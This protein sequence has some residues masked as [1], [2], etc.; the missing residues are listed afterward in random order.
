MTH[1]APSDD[2]G[3]HWEGTPAELAA[4]KAYKQRKAVA[5][6]ELG[7]SVEWSR[8]GDPFMDVYVA[9][10][11]FANRPEVRASIQFYGRPS[12]FGIDGGMVSKLTI[13]R[14]RTDLIKRVL[15]HEHEHVETLFN[16]D[17]GPDFD[18]LDRDEVART[19]YHAV[20]EELN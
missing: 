15:G 2:E 9:E 10:R 4:W 17:R 1:E 3:V 8:T 5:F 11:P 6:I 18:R 12:Q 20:L 16:Y 19:L 13:Q 14:T 7:Y